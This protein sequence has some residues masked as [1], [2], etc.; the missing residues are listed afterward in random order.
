MKAFPWLGT[1]LL[2]ACLTSANGGAQ[3]AAPRP[4]LAL[5]NFTNAALINRADYEPLEWS[6]PELISTRLARNP[7]IDL[8]DR[9]RLQQLLDEQNLGASGRTE[10]ESAARV[11]RLL[12]AKYMVFGT[13]MIDR[14]NRLRMD[15]RVLEV[16]TSKI[17]HSETFRDV[18][19]NED[20]SYAVDSL[21]ERLHRNLK[22]PGRV[23]LEQPGSSPNGPAARPAADTGR[24]ARETTK[25]PSPPETPAV[26]A[27]AN[28]VATATRPAGGS[29]RS[30]GLVSMGAALR[31]AARGGATATVVTMLKSAAVETPSLAQDVDDIVKGLGKS[32]M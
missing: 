19:W 12:G 26:S 1:A 9:R 10:S 8:V 21:A 13:V 7:E 5:M 15:A 4:T 17:V 24:Q 3:T 20:V 25:L 29:S 27:P 11:G 6:V 23:R 22:L 31:L 14:R 32:G 28:A 30:R 16:E 2:T 18:D